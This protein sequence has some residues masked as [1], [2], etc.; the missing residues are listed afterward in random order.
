MVNFFL[1]LLSFFGWKPKPLG[2]GPGKMVAATGSPPTIRPR[3][4]TEAQQ[5]RD[6]VTT[7]DRFERAH[8]LGVARPSPDE[9]TAA[10][11]LLENLLLPLAGFLRACTHLGL[12]WPL[13]PRGTDPE[14]WLTTTLKLVAEQIEMV[15][16]AIRSGAVLRAW[17]AVENIMA[18][19]VEHQLRGCQPV[20]IYPRGPEARREVHVRDSV[21]SAEHPEGRVIIP[22]LYEHGRGGRL[23]I[24]EHGG[25]QLSRVTLDR[26]GWTLSE[27]WIAVSGPAGRPKP[28]SDDGDNPRDEN[29]PPAAPRP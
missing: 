15:V 8:V 19:D 28:P 17:R 12:S 5:A 29:T 18:R 10:W 11:L 21:R 14:G 6:A 26:S 7:L 27:G 25:G 3:I 24:A 4:Y 20:V 9:A 16:T 22:R 2:A 1:L 13:C 23:E